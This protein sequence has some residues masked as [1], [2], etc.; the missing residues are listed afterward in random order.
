MRLNLLVARKKIGL[1]QR[2]LAEKVGI[3]LDKYSNIETGRQLTVDVEL[4]ADIAR[5]LSNNDN[6]LFLRDNSYKIRKVETKHKAG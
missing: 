4:A 2:Q 3:S 5:A 6:R 1:T